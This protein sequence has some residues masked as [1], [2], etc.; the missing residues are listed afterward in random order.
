MTG[1]GRVDCTWAWGSPVLRFWDFLDPSP[2]AFPSFTSL[3]ENLPRQTGSWA[4]QFSTYV[5]STWPLVC[6]VSSWA[7]AGPRAR[8]PSGR[9]T[10]LF[11]GPASFPGGPALGGTLCL[12]KPGLLW[13]RSD[14]PTLKHCSGRAGASVLAGPCHSTWPEGTVESCE[15]HVCGH[16]KGLVNVALTFPYKLLSLVGKGSKF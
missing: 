11:W 14:I 16:R 8:A 2:L 5:L 10:D 3:L 15:Q 12:A 6:D 4:S 7:T 1:P 13:Q 9:L